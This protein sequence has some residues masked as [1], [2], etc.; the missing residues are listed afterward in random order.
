MLTLGIVNDRGS[1]GGDT[2]SALIQFQGRSESDSVRVVTSSV[3]GC[4]FIFNGGIFPSR[5]STGIQM[6]KLSSGGTTIPF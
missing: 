1:E 2:V 3:D 4:T 6:S 5:R